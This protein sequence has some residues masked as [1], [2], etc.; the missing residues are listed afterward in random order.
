[1]LFNQ[2]YSPR[3]MFPRYVRYYNSS[4]E[5]GVQQHTYHVEYNGAI[6]FVFTLSI[7]ETE[8][9]FNVDHL[10]STTVVVKDLPIYYVE[11]ERLLTIGFYD[12]LEKLGVV[13]D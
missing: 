6:I 12:L 2:R 3:A 13:I 4:Y 1:M 10:A 7:S 8:A 11:C 9:V 5:D